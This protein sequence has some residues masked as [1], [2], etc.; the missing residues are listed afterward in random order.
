MTGSVRGMSRS[1]LRG[2]GQFVLMPLVLAF[3]RRPVA[4][5]PRNYSSGPWESG[6]GVFTIAISRRYTRHLERGSRPLQGFGFGRTS[7][8]AL[9]VWRGRPS[10]GIW[11]S[12]FYRS[13][14]AKRRIPS[15]LSKRFTPFV[16]RLR[17]LVGRCRLNMKSRGTFS[18]GPIRFVGTMWG[19]RSGIICF[20]RDLRRC[21]GA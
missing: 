11:L 19:R 3:G 9:C 15:F 16:V 10:I 5:D 7:T 6:A 14:S 1:L 20:S 13:L 4:E 12:F 8:A 17:G 18:G 21:F 2:I